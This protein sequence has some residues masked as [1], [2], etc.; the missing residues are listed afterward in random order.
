MARTPV[1]ELTM[2]AIMAALERPLPLLEP[3]CE[4]EPA[5]CEL[6]VEVGVVEDD[7]KV[8]EEATGLAKLLASECKQPEMLTD[9]VISAISSEHESHSL[10]NARMYVPEEGQFPSQYE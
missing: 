4:P 2:V 6:E 10:S 1:T 3:D 8:E 9:C 5:L 7:A